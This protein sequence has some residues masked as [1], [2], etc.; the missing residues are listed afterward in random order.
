[1]K[2]DILYQIITEQLGKP[3]VVLPGGF[4]PPHKGHFEALKYMLKTTGAKDAKIFVGKKD[5]DG[6]TQD[7]SLKIWNL[8]KKYLPANIEVVGVTGADKGGREATP[9]SMTYDFVEDNGRDYSQIYV[10]A[11]QD[12][13]KRFE[14]LVKNKEKYPNA[15]IIAIPP[16]YGRISGTET[17]KNIKQKTEKI[18]NFIPADVKEVEQVRAILGI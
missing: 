1:M 15:A 2:F 3:L 17:R 4:K 18:L 8:Y 10:G 13:L 6:I 5:R 12:D 11:G 7:Q 9:L 14:G 16:Q